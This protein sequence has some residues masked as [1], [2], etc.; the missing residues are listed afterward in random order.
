MVIPIIPILVAL[1]ILGLL[2]WVVRTLVP[3]L[4]IPEPIGTVIYVILVVL[5]VVYLL[6]LL[7]GQSFIR[8]N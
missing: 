7:T 3:V 5:V 6:S 2:F 8:L 1:I 4:G